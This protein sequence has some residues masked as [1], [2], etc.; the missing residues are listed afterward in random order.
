MKG[1]AGRL[2][3]GGCGAG[4]LYSPAECAIMGSESG[5]SGS[6]TVEKGEG[7]SML[8]S[9]VFAFNA[10][11]PILLLVALGWFLKERKLLSASTIKQMNT[12][13]FRF[14]ISCMM[15]RNIYTLSSLVDI[16]VDAMVL[17]LVTIGL[18]TV[19]GWLEAQVFTDQRRRRGVMIQNSFRS[20]FAVIGTTLAF[21]LGGETARAVSSSMQAPTIIYYNVMAVICL[22]IYSDRPDR[23]V[24]VKGVLKQIAVNPLIL[25]Q[26]AGLVCLALR[27]VIPRSAQGE[28]VFT[29]KGNLPFL[30][31]AVDYLADMA[32]PAILILI[33]A[34]VNFKAV[35][36]MKKELIVG[37]IQRLMAAP[38]VGFGLAIL[39]RNLGLIA[40]TPALFSAL[41]G[42]YGSP[43]VAVA[44][45]MT[46][47]IGGDA[48]LARQYVIWTSAFSMVTLFF[49]IVVLH[50]AG[51][52]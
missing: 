7:F 41:V 35:G 38:A 45:V 16:R 13:V 34:Q 11:A 2:F 21:A 48:E 26:V 47:E 19:I 32:T 14:G 28:L 39:A 36:G 43:S 42:I 3:S 29:L 50:A 18:L 20:N 51:L 40:V 15:F 30:Y 9:V 22:T 52:V 46:E 33:G 17:V 49:W 4:A 25:G 6:L 12:V 8:D 44:G 27:E 24:D 31:T 10:I 1:P 37:V 23:A 5:R